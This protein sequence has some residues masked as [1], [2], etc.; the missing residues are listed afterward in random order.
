MSAIVRWRIGRAKFAVIASEA[1]QSTSSVLA[2]DCFVASL[3]AVTA[4]LTLSAN[5]RISCAAF[6]H[7][8]D[9]LSRMLD[10]AAFGRNR[11]NADNVIDSKV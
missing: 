7:A 9:V 1:K 8:G 10:H 4:E 6:C 2:L 5:L 11:P 3:L